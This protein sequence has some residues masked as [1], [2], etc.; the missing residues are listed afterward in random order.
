VSTRRNR[1][2]KRVVIWLALMYPLG[3][4]IMFAVNTWVKA[5][6]GLEV[7]REDE[8]VKSLFGSAVML[9]SCVLLCLSAWC[10]SIYHTR[11]TSGAQPAGK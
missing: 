7:D 1:G 6:L 8:L 4:L 2:A 9:A 11:H 5:R 10:V 3:V